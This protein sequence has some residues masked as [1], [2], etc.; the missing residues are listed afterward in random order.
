MLA[1]LWFKLKTFRSRDLRTLP[2][3]NIFGSEY[4]WEFPIQAR[5]ISNFP[6]GSTL[7]S[8]FAEFLNFW[9][10]KFPPFGILFFGALSGHHKE[11]TQ[12]Q[13]IQE[14]LHNFSSTKK[15]KSMWVFPKMGGF[16]PK[17]SILIGFS[18]YFSPS[19][20]GFFPYFWKQPCTRGGVH[21]LTY[22]PEI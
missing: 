8:N 7:F 14:C 2:E 17:S 5:F 9:R 22:T 3:T 13:K 6:W 10:G 15:P 12:I 1:R 16:P 19:I 4:W 18:P 11:N 20:L 21:H